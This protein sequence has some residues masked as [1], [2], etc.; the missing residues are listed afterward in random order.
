[1]KGEY[2]KHKQEAVIGRWIKTNSS[3]M[4]LLQYLSKHIRLEKVLFGEKGKHV[5]IKCF[6]VKQKTLKSYQYL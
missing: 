4:F 1:M 6:L 2:C 5:R 3:A